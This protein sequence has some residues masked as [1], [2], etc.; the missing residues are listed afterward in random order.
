MIYKDRMETLSVTIPI[1]V[2]EWV[3]K[4]GDLGEMVR[5]LLDQRM[6]KEAEFFIPEYKK[7]RRPHRGRPRKDEDPNYVPPVKRPRGRPPK[8]KEEKVLKEAK[9][10]LDESK[11]IDIEC[12]HIRIQEI[13]KIIYRGLEIYAVKRS[14]DY[15]DAECALLDRTNTAW[16]CGYVEVP[17]G[18]YSLLKPRGYL[19]ITLSDLNSYNLAHVHGGYTYLDNGI[20][21]VL[22]DNQRS[23]LGWDYR[24]YLDT[25]DCVTYQEILKEG[26]KVVDSMK[27][28]QST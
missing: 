4:N 3:D 10:K 7:P 17:I 25:E 13:K 23:F 21:L 19:D 2:M 12:D 11:I 20:P 6:N 18:M 9:N 14:T 26:I 15:S 8:S 22:D 1:D 28:F 5:T 24:H 27:E 16:W